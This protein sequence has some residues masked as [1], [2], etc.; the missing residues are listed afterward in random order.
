MTRL[1]RATY[2]LMV[3]LPPATATVVGILVLTQI[4]TLRDLLGVGLS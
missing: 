3:S 2:S 1:S 4:P